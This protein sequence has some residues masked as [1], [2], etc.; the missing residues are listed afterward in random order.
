LFSALSGKPPAVALFCATFLKPEML[1]IYRHV[2]GLRAFRPVVL[3]QKREGN[4][5]VRALEIIPRSPWRFLSRGAE[6]SSGRPWQITMGEVRRIT[7]ILQREECALLHVFFGNAAVHLRPLLRRA[8]VPVVVSFHGSDVAGSMVSPGYA[9]AVRE[10][11]A[12]A[13]VVPC[14]SDQL[15]GAVER[16][17]CP[18]EKLRLMRTVLPEIP[19]LQRHPPA[20]GA[21]KIVQAARLV[22][23]KGLPTALRAFAEFAR[24]FPLA[25]FT[26]AGEG[27]MENELRRL[28]EELHLTGRVQFAGFLP[29]EALQQLFHESHIFLHPSE[30]AGGDVE[31]VPNALLEAMA[32]GLPVV[33]T[34]HGG[35]PEVVT[36]GDSGLLS[37]ERDAAGIAAALLRLADSP[38]LFERLSARGAASVNDQFSAGRQIAAV[39]EIYAD[40]IAL[41]PRGK[42][43]TP[44][45]RHEP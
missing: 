24:R 23:K 38:E 4:W 15:A 12:L 25:T 20:N 28:V 40:A 35:I 36:D 33:A 3:T 31:G 18:P 27:P 19:F 14:R 2:T 8:P 17:G 11:F 29:Q 41:S 21:W 34:R 26:I 6:K 45:Q 37:A 32:G 39:E 13:D 42:P 5:P 22:A 9:D 43:A 44:P 16:L 7:A 1:H 30:T 10:M